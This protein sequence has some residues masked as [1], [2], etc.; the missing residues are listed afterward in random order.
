[1]YVTEM[2][3]H[4]HASPRAGLWIAAFMV[5]CATFLPAP[6]WADDGDGAAGA[7]AAEPAA[8]IELD[9]S[10]V[11]HAAEAVDEAEAALEAVM[12]ATPA[13]GDAA[14]GDE[15][16][17]QTP[18]PT[19][20]E[21]KSEADLASTGGSE[22]DTT[23][24]SSDTATDSTAAPASVGEGPGRTAP[25]APLTTPAA[26]SINVNVSVRIGSA[27][28]NGSVSQI[29]TT[30]APSSTPAS[31]ATQAASP[32]AAGSVMDASR[33]R[34]GSPWYW[35][36]NCRDL[37][38]IPV[39][40][41]TASV[42]E[43]FPR[44]W[45]W[46]WNCGENSDEYHDETT[47]Q[48]R[49]SNTN[50]SIRLSSPGDNG[51][52]TQTT[53]AISA[54]AASVSLPTIEVPTVTLTTPAITVTMPAGGITIPS[55]VV[56]APTEAL[57]TQ[58]APEAAAEWPVDVALGSVSA[59]APSTSLT[60]LT[61]IVVAPRPRAGIPFGADRRHPAAPHAAYGILGAVTASPGAA[62][63]GA[64]TRTRHD[65]RKAKAAPRRPPSRSAPDPKLPMSPVSGTSVS[66][67]GTGG[68]P[69]G[70]LPIFL[71]LPF[72][73]VMLDLARRVALE[74]ATWPSGHR[75]RAPATPG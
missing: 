8:T 19:E 41:P 47:D 42:G 6:A 55:I 11:D 28:D 16:A 44:T 51:P 25:S 39:V 60:A 74:R 29:A 54:G 33:E 2:L 35:E 24:S 13:D 43:S 67:A 26:V 46:I 34:A 58:L 37:P 71:A 62:V 3:H 75:R 31:T 30:V 15:T 49:P 18:D 40:S 1:M 64:S 36:W 72:I 23:A 61:P 12:A 48:Y 73:A 57:T 5:S 50:V 70:S 45:T 27:G 10:L 59:S 32:S 38:L 21:P 68:S 66:A 53:V 20:P 56:E 17:G 52:V 22:P 63:R 65:P 4:R 7:S 14:G 9:T 69:G